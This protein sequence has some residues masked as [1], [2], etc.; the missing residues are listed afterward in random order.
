[1]L[2]I[3][4]KDDDSYQ[5]C[6]N[7]RMH[8]K[9]FKLFQLIIYSFAQWR[10]HSQWSIN[11]GVVIANWKLNPMPARKDLKH[12]LPSN[13]WRLARANSIMSW[14]MNDLW[15][16]LLINVAC[17]EKLLQ[18][19]SICSNNLFYANMQHHKPLYW[20]SCSHATL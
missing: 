1:M 18:N 5:K 13:F 6:Q 19:F 2:W 16:I 17:T 3:A 9:D 15:N 20:F 7:G 11:W 8:I 14:V 10:Y 12:S 4:W